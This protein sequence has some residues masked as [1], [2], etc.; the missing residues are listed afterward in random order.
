MWPFRK[1]QV[2]PPPN[3]R[4]GDDRAWF[5][6]TLNQWEF[7]IDG[8]E[9]R[10]SG[11]DFDDRAFAWA[12]EAI[13][14]IKQL[15][16]EIDK[17]VFQEL[18]GSPCDATTRALLTVSLDDYCSEGKMELAFVGDDSWGDFG[19]HVIVADGTVLES[20]GGD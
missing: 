11:R 18:E 13:L 16:E 2:Q 17:H 19:V 14:S 10:L 5:S 6:A 1:K 4:S 12:R 7:E 3:V 20:Y 15:K 9:F 8:T